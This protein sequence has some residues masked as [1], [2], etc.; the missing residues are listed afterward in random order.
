MIGEVFNTINH[1][2]VFTY[3]LP[4]MLGAVLWMFWVWLDIKP[5][6]KDGEKP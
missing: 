1:G 4:I 6:R 5:R 3:L 2:G